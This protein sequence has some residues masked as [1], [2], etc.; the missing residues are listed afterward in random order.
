[1]L[2]QEKE[3]EKLAAIAREKEQAKLEAIVNEE[4]EA[5]AFLEKIKQA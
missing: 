1:M 3:Q 2:K 5:K 4:I